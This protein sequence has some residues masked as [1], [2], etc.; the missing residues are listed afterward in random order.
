VCDTGK[1]AQKYQGLDS[2]FLPLQ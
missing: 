2:Q 1:S